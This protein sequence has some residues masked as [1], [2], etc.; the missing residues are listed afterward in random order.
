MIS[1][2]PKKPVGVLTDDFVMKYAAFLNWELLSK[3]YEFSVEL[4]RIFFHRVNW[5]HILERQ[6][7]HES[8]L[9]EMAVSFNED[10]WAKISRFQRLSESF[11]HDFAN[12]LDWDYILCYQNI[13]NSFIND[14]KQYLSD[15]YSFASD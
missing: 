8:F 15:V 7:F 12:D 9:R 3:N 6:R 13:S 10:C 1:S 4:L 2:E 5:A 11:I 14:H